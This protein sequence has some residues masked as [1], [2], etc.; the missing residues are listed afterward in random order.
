MFLPTFPVA[1]PICSTRK[2]RN[3]KAAKTVPKRV[4]EAEASLDP[5]GNARLPFAP[6]F[7]L[8]FV[9]PFPQRRG[10]DGLK[11]A[12][13]MQSKKNNH[14]EPEVWKSDSNDEQNVQ[15]DTQEQQREEKGEMYQQHEQNDDVH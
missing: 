11:D 7:E 12:Y 1:W 14:T 4:P 6:T 5:L 13:D 3:I 2:V 8:P 10:D 15:C 9:P